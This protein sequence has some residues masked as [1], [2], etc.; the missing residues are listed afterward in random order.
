MLYGGKKNKNQHTRPLLLLGVHV[1]NVTNSNNNFRENAPRFGI[2]FSLFRWFV[3]R[4]V[5]KCN[6]KKKTGP[7]RR[8]RHKQRSVLTQT[9]P[10]ILISFSFNPFAGIAVG[11]CAT[12][13]VTLSSRTTAKGESRFK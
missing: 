4:V 12:D 9:R 13:S 5:I 6:Q 10:G 11:S 8:R 1:L 3:C 7:K 2:G